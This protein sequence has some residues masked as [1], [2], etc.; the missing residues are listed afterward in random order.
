MTATVTTPTRW[1]HEDTFAPLPV[2]D[3]PAPGTP[4]W[5]RIVTASKIPALA[6]LSQYDS[7]VSLWAKATGR[8]SADTAPTEVTERGDAVEPALLAWLQLKL[9]DVTVRAG[10]A[11]AHP[12][13]ETWQ[14]TPDGLVYEGTGR[15]RRRTP[16]ALVECKTAANGGAWG[17]PG[18][19]QIPAA[20]QAQCAWQMHVTGA[21][22]VYVPALVNPGIR[23]NLW[24]VRRE[25]VADQ[26]PELAA[27]A[28]AWEECVNEDRRPDLD[29]APMTLEA[30]REMSPEI[31][32]QR[33]A[34]VDHWDAVE[35]LT[36]KQA[37]TAAEERLRLAQSQVI[38]TAAG[39]RT[40]T[41]P[42]GAVIATLQARK[43]R[44]GSFGKPFLKLAA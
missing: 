39:A 23:L 3:A 14:A 31:D 22:L 27:R 30:V 11:T 32:P 18:T 35:L 8:M 9:G 24:V 34:T 5:A 26:I 7:P 13:R 36:A 2:T 25:D 15:S 16:Y 19:A 43:A 33:T 21:H 1:A 10:Y 28:T 17:E 38:E 12:D 40:I 20:Y 42:E 44:D 37:L 41:T 4:E 29:G 6:G